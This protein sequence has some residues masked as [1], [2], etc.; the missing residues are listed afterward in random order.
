MR[1]ITRTYPRETEY[2]TLYPISDV[3]WGA[4]ECMERELQSYLKKIEA[5]PTAVVLLAG[6]RGE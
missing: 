5:D 3:H 1:V 6:A 2:I 4:A